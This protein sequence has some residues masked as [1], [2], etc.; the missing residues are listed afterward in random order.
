MMDDDSRKSLS[1]KS[2]DRV[3]LLAFSSRKDDRDSLCRIL[4]NSRWNVTEA[5]TCREALDALS[6]RPIPVIVCNRELPDR[7]WKSLLEGCRNRAPHPSPVVFRRLAGAGLWAE[8][9][10]LGRFDVLGTPFDAG[11][12]ARV[13]VL[14]WQSCNNSGA[15]ARAAG[16]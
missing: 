10:N 11:E 15:P 16:R 12:V 4:A 2:A 9:L 8:V 14:A 7:G 6:R 3:P 5:R 1:Q 13:S